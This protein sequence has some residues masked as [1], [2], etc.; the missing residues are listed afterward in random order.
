M[1]DRHG[2]AIW[3]S[4][5]ALSAIVEDHADQHCQQLEALQLKSNN[6]KLEQ[7]ATNQVMRHNILL[8]NYLNSIGISLFTKIVL[9][10]YF[11]FKAN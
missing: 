7:Q 9:F 10:V 8:T 5:A 1:V 4:V 2:S 11:L 3:D 6:F